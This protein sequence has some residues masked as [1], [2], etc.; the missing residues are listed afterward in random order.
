MNGPPGMPRLDPHTP[1]VAS[2]REER[3]V[4][5]ARRRPETA[6]GLTRVT[7]RLRNLEASMDGDRRDVIL[8]ALPGARV[9]RRA[10]LRSL[11]GA[12]GA[13]VWGGSGAAARTDLITC[14]ATATSGITG[15]VLIGPMCP[16]MRVDEPC[17][18]HPF[19]ATLIIRDSQ[20][21]ELCAASSLEDG[22]FVVGLPPGSYELIPLTGPGGLPAAAS[23][24]VAVAPGQY[25]AVTVSY[26]SGI[27]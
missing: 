20:G 19:A 27:R 22:R 5:V 18:D 26:D 2:P 4:V 15:L 8:S 16:V 23:Q 10:L 21:R 17:P 24:W 11:A 25:T 13:L 1:G 14:D 9:A 3:P 7:V 12:L 6:L